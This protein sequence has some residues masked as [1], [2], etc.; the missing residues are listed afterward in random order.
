M[1]GREEYELLVLRPPPTR[2][3]PLRRPP[4]PSVTAAWAVGII[5]K[6]PSEKAGLGAVFLLK[7]CARPYT[8]PAHT[9]VRRVERNAAVP[10]HFAEGVRKE[11]PWF[12]R[13]CQV[14]GD[15][16]TPGKGGQQ[17]SGLVCED[18]AGLLLLSLFARMF[19]GSFSFRPFSK[20]PSSATFLELLWATPGSP[21]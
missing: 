2:G 17:F 19:L 10:T 9:L 5:P 20:G 6:E 1:G 3:D 11:L 13:G 16:G 7:R 21:L 18:G 4:S 8:H 14:F 12:S 15:L